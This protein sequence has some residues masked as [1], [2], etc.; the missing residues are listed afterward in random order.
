RCAL[1]VGTRPGLVVHTEIWLVS[2]HP[3]CG[4]KGG[5]AEIFFMPQP[6]LLTRRGMSATLAV[7]RR[8]PITS[9][10]LPFCTTFPVLHLD[11]RKG[12]RD[13]SQTGKKSHTQISGRVRR[14]VPQ[15]RSRLRRQASA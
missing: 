3:V 4:A 8:I 9:L 1:K 2:D 6:L 15:R 11:C 13:H 10:C 12:M 14:Q 5:F 7:S